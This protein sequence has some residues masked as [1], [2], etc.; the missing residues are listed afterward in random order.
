MGSDWLLSNQ[1]IRSLIFNY[2]GMGSQDEIDKFCA[3]DE[4][5]VLKY[6]LQDQEFASIL[7]AENNFKPREYL[8]V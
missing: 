1:S 5:P 2:G 7:Y 6:P 3:F 4:F 8:T